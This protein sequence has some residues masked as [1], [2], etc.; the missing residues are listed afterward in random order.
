MEET[1]IQPRSSFSACLFVMTDTLRV[2]S[3]NGWS[4]QP[5]AVLRA[6]CNEKLNI[7]FL[8]VDVIEGVK[9]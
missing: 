4:L 6:V 3:S 2:L 9:I 7:V 5:G 1:H 8:C